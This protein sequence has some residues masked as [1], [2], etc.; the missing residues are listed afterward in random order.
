MAPFVGRACCLDIAEPF[1]LYPH[2][3]QW[4]IGDSTV[5]TTALEAQSGLETAEAKSQLSVCPSLSSDERRR[6]RLWRR[7]AGDG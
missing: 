3:E 6:G 7:V 5:Q 1:C 2:G 4:I